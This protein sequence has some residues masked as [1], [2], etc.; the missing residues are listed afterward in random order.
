MKRIYFV[1]HGETG[2]NISGYMQSPQEPLNEHGLRQA[3]VVGERVKGLTVDRLIASTMKRAQQTAEAIAKASDLTVESSDLFCEI[4]DPTSVYSDSAETADQQLIEQFRKARLE[5]I[6]DPDWHFEDEENPHDFFERIKKALDFLDTL[7]EEN[8]VVVTHGNF[9]RT[10]IGFII[11]DQVYDLSDMYKFK[12]T[13]TTSNT[14]ITIVLC[15]GKTKR[16]LTWN[17][18]AHFAE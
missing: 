6:N 18:H 17:D 7:P 3:D 5:N 15:E 8:I 1:R 11:Q 16:L 12:R 14:G 9:L 13:I 4:K 10:L 2:G